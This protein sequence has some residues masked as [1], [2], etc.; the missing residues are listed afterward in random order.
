MAEPVRPL[1]ERNVVIT[2]PA[3][4]GSSLEK[5]L[6]AAGARAIPFPVVRI[7]AVSGE[8][9]ALLRRAVDGLGAGEYAGLIVTSVN[10][11]IHLAPLLREA[12]V[13][14]AALDTVCFAIGNKT[15]AALREL[16][17]DPLLARE[18]V[19]ESLL[20]TVREQISEVTGASFLFPRARRGRTVLIDGL[21]DAGAR[22]D[23]LTAYETLE[24]TD[25]PD[26]PDDRDIHWV[27][28][29]SPSAV[30]AF[31]ARAAIPAGARVACI[32]PTTARAAEQE[33][34]TVAAVPEEQT[35][36]A[37]VAAMVAASEADRV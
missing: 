21:R 6:T 25:G 5:A 10:A 35:V 28:F 12:G 24:V 34:L 17:V 27:T 19:A 37:M 8:E 16:G 18:S 20:V 33:G 14:L 31:L 22:V 2:R 26:L 36:E 3:E 4:Q 7:E 32:G 29:T 13:E 23:A 15:A 11:V 1:A 30:E 9:R